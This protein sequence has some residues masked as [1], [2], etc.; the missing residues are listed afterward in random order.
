MDEAFD[1]ERFRAI[2]PLSAAPSQWRG[3]TIICSPVTIVLTEQMRALANK[4]DLGRS[5]PCDVFVFGIGEPSHA[6][7]TKIGGRPYRPAM[8]KWPLGLTGYPMTFVAQFN[9][10][11]S[12]QFIENIPGDILLVFSTDDDICSDDPQHRLHF[13]WYS[14][15]MNAPSCS[16]EQV[17]Q[18]KWNFH[19]CYGVRYRTCDYAGNEAQSTLAAVVDKTRLEKTGVECVTMG[20]DRLWGMKIGGLP[21]TGRG[22]GIDPSPW[23][24]T[25]LCSIASVIPAHDTPF[26]WVNHPQPVTV[27]DVIKDMNSFLEI[28]AGFVLEFYLQA[29]G[30]VKWWIQFA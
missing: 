21:I 19:T 22:A 27:S 16:S 9:F 4:R 12:K 30:S 3:G 18:T 24:G 1:F 6:S 29:D 15:E 11:A 25:F 5:V 26:P 7:A 20:L 10:N 2:F 17:P 13:E 23:A 14:T 28:R 8:L